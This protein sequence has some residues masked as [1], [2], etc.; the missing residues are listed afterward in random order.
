MKKIFH[1]AVAAAITLAYAGSLSAADQVSPFDGGGLSLSGQNAE[2]PAVP[3]PASAEPAVKE[4]PVPAHG[5]SAGQLGEMRAHNAGLLG[6]HN[7][8]LAFEDERVERKYRP[9]A[10]YEAPGYLIMSADFNFNSRQAKLLMA[11]K[12]PADATLVIFTDYDDASVKESILRTYESV[13]PRSRVKVIALRG[14]VQGFWAR[15]GIPVPAIDKAGKLVVV[16]AVYGHRFE[17]D[18]QIAQFF[19]AGLEKHQY[20]YE[21]GNYMANAA[22]DCIM[23]N[24]G[25]HTQIPDSVF[26]GQYGCRQ[27]I[28]LPFVD[29]IGHIDEHVRFV[30]E[31]VVV[32]DLKEYQD[33]LQ[34]K[35][36]TVHMLPKPSGPYETY[37]NSLLMNDQII[38][39]VFGR[40]TD[41]QALAVYER[42]GLKASG[43]DSKALSNQGQ[44]SVHCITMTYPK[45]PMTNL[46]KALGATEI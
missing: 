37:V 2:L 31:K 40:S 27:M 20:Y 7:K 34:G 19:G 15:D 26:V 33:I 35:G 6:V 32:T 28:R 13:I 36:F 11:S 42:L 1:L 22:G 17:P 18:A 3:A 5:F 4:A 46:L 29:G 21:G 12:L 9:Y 38:V 30:S 10:D 23:V 8:G 43:A 39:P 41:A 44:G 45:V 14:A 25:Y 16:D 24:H